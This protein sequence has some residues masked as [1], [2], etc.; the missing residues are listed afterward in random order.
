MYNEHDEKDPLKSFADILTARVSLHIPYSATRALALLK[1]N[2]L[3]RRRRWLYS[4]DRK[5]QDY[6]C[7][8]EI[9]AAS[10]SFDADVVSTYVPF[11]YV[12]SAEV[13]SR[14]LCSTLRTVVLP[15]T[16]SDNNRIHEAGKD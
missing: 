12:D 3:R 6:P 11:S 2:I 13:H 5:R 14:W 15:T 10:T 8:C 9:F 1:M 4:G 7:D 16:C